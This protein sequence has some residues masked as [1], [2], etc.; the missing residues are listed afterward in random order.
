MRTGFRPG[1]R[2]Q[3]SYLEGFA[4]L[5]PVL[6]AAYDSRLMVIA[7]VLRV[8]R[9]FIIGGVRAA[10]G[11]NNGLIRRETHLVPNRIRP[12]DLSTSARFPTSLAGRKHTVDL[13]RPS[14]P[15]GKLGAVAGLV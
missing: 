12:K 9:R 14:P 1:K 8:A 15:H 7:I 10:D 5:Y 3:V 11:F 4:V 6:D 2:R 13:L